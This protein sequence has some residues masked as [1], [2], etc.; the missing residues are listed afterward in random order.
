MGDS[1]SNAKT[2]EEE[3]ATNIAVLIDDGEWEPD[4]C[5]QLDWI[6]FAIGAQQTRCQRRVQVQTGPGKKRGLSIVA[7]ARPP[8][9][10]VV[11]WLARFASSI[12]QSAF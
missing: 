10:R 4:L 6:L 2:T 7:S 5:C 12:H 3:R 9:A 1:Y 8:V 11:W